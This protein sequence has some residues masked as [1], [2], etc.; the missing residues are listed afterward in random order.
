MFVKVD[1]ES[2]IENV[3]QYLCKPLQM[4][5]YHDIEPPIGILVREL[6]YRKKHGLI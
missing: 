3:T 6:L 4:V 2:T 1:V 5:R